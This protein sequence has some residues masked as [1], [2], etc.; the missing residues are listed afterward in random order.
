M[1]KIK[2]IRKA[3]RI[4]D[5]TFEYILKELKLGISEKEVSK[6]IKTFIKNKKASMSFKPIVAF[7]KNSATPHHKATNKKLTKNTIVL[8]DLGV[9][10]KN[11]CS[12]MTRTVYFGKAT[13]KFKNI[14][15]VVL[16]AQTKAVEYIKNQPSKQKGKLVAK[17]IDNAARDYIISQGYPSIPHSLGHG[18]GKKVHEP[19]HISPRSRGRLEKGIVFSIEPG[20]YLKN[21]GG[22]RIEDLYYYDGKIA[23]LISKAGKEIIEL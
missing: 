22:V 7:G 1:S 9:K 17:E 16:N 8:L 15:K 5:E 19:P 2:Y 12:D 18:I 11:Y 4:G 14:Y 10:Y 13:K 21:L 3:C 6:L 20:I 23:Q